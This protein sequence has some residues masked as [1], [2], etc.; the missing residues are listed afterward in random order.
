MI[1][2]VVFL[3]FLERSIPCTV[4]NLLAVF[5]F[6]LMVILGGVWSIPLILWMP[7]SI[8]TF[9]IVFV[10]LNL[11]VWKL[12]V[13]ESHGA[14]AFHDGRYAEAE[15][16]F[17]K[18]WTMAQ[19]LGPKD[20]CRGRLLV[21][22]LAVATRLQGNYDEAEAFCRE[23]LSTNKSELDGEYPRTVQVMECLAGIYIILARYRHALPL[24]EKALRMR[25]ALQAEEPLEYAKSLASVAI[26]WCFQER[27]DLAEPY[28][29]RAFEIYQ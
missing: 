16:Y 3:K 8:L 27:P 20:Q 21:W 6:V 23:W 14:K 5:V 12:L 25:E 1:L 7:L 24:L 17:R 22:S 2:I 28:F 11:R 18:S 13:Y 26:F 15:S 9:F 19:S 10:F 29:Q 4:G